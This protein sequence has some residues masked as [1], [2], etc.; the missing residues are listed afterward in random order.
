MKIGSHV[1]FSK[2]GLLNAVQ[3]A[4]SYGSTSFM[5]YTGAPQNTK[6]KPMEEQYVEEGLKVME[7][8]GIH[9][10]VVH[11]P[12]IINLGSYKN[13]TFELAVSFLRQEI[14]RAEYIGVKNIVLHPGAYTDK[15]AEYGINRIAEGLNEVLHEGQT[16]NIALETM[17]GKGSEIGRSFEELAAII[18]KVKLNDKLAVCFDTC[19]THDAGYD[20]VNNFDGVM[21]EFNR[22]I[23]L[24]RLA[25]LH[26]N[27]SKN[28]RGAAKDRH[29]P[30]GTGLIGFQAI[31]YIV[32]H[33][34]AKDK[35]I[36]L[37]TPW[38]GKDKTDQSPMYEVE[39]A[40]LR[41]KLNERFTNNFLGDVEQLTY[42]FAKKDIKPRDYIIGGWERLQDKKLKKED[43][44]EP[45]DR[46]FDM[47]VEDGVLPDESEEGINKRIIAWLAGVV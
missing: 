43:A 46:L 2:K 17:A 47:V 6:R 10:I 4:L 29:A 39:I 19:H 25:V 7:D 40:L 34:A 30:I 13:H 33:E 22:V 3:E 24:D 9:D 20:I 44:R 5:I 12:Y 35:P 1:S 27:D 45:F 36:I 28:F 11:A 26:I 16:A 37:E 32:H 38:I 18:E 21:E 41:H 14:E 8:H 15:D 42:Y 23:G 31:D